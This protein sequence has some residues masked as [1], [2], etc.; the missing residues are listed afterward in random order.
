MSRKK[1]E[2]RNCDFKIKEEEIGLLV[3]GSSYEIMRGKGGEVGLPF[4]VYFVF[5]LSRE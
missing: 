4:P 5:S 1:V 2:M 3:C